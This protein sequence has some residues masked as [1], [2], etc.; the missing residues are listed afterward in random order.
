MLTGLPVVELDT[1]KVV[2]ESSTLILET[3]IFLGFLKKTHK[4]GQFWLQLIFYILNIHQLLLKKIAALMETTRDRAT[5]T[6]NGGSTVFSVQMH[7]IG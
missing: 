7:T 3:L 1:E 2:V 4:F 5:A 6:V